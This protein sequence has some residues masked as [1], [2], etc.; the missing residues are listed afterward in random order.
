GQ[1]LP[2]ELRHGLGIQVV[3]QV[4]GNQVRVGPVRTRSAGDRQP[5]LP[6]DS[7]N[8]VRKLLGERTFR[9]L[10]ADLSDLRGFQ[11][12]VEPSQQSSESQAHPRVLHREVETEAWPAET[13]PRG[14]AA[15]VYPY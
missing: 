10:L 7:M 5:A 15:V 8:P 1:A 14:I 9:D 11:G 2:L 4:A 12:I 3:V 13:H 6:G